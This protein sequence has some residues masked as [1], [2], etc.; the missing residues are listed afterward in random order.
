MTDLDRQV[1]YWDAAAATKTFT[2][3]VYWPWLAAYDR[4]S[5]VV[6][7]YGCGYGRTTAE[8]TAHGFAAAYGVDVSPEMVARARREHPG[9]RFGVTAEPPEPPGPP[10]PPGP[11]EQMELDG[12]AGDVGSTG[13]ADLFLLFAVLTCVPGDDAQRAIIAEARRVLKVGGALYISDLLLQEDER[14]RERYAR[15]QSRFG[16]LG[17]FE[18]GDGAVCRHHTREHLLRLLDGFELVAER[19][20]SVGTMN[21]HTSRGVQLLARRRADGESDQ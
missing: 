14:N 12:C 15:D 21:G 13:N 2:H 7:D 16:T 9:G 11:P 5:A 10:G 19:D 6:I 1:T 18:T 4:A 3:P 8:L 17:V 20:I